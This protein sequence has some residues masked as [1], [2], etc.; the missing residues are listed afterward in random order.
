MESLPCRKCGHELS[1]RPPRCPHCGTDKPEVTFS[2][3]Q[4]FKAQAVVSL[5]VLAVGAGTALLVFLLWSIF[6]G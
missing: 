5:F 1:D 2:P 4:A 3:A 6:P